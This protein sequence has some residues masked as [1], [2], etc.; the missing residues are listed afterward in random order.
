ML[1]KYQTI[2]KIG[3]VAL[4]A[5]I[6]I[7]AGVMAAGFHGSGAGKHSASAENQQFQQQ[8]ENSLVLGEHYRSDSPAGC[9]ENPDKGNGKALRSRNCTMECDPSED[10]PGNMTRTHARPEDGSCGNCPAR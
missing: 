6:L 7:P 8:A 1:K 9:E 4:L 3:I 5:L 2:K 10:Q